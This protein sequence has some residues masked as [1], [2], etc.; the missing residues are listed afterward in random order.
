MKI[1][2]VSGVYYPMTNGVAVFAHN[3]AT[4]LAKRG[5]EVIV[6]CPSFNGKRHI[7]KKEG[8][9]K[10]CLK[11]I[12]LP[13][14]PDQMSEVPAKKKLFGKD[15]PRIIYRRG[16]WISPTPHREISKILRSFRPDI[17]HSQTCDPIGLAV[18]HFAREHRVPFVTTGHTYP[19]T[20]T[21]QLT[22]LK[23][24][25]KPLDAALTS[26]LVGYQRHSD[27]ATM[28]T[29]MAIEDL[30]MKRRREFKVPIEALSN[31]VDLTSFKPTKAKLA[32][33]KK[34]KIPVDRPIVLYVGRVDPEKTISIVLEAFAKLL[35]KIPEAVFVVVGDGTDKAH[36]MELAKYMQIE[37]SVKFLGKILPPELQ[38]VYK[39]GDVFA[40]ASEIETQGIVLIEAAASGLPIIAVDKGAVK[41]VCQNERNGFLCQPG[42][43]I[44]GISESMYKILSDKE[45]RQKMSE[46]SV[47]ISKKHDINN[48]LARFEEIYFEAMKRKAE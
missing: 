34:Y 40:T 32:T 45:L 3:L 41:E 18:S 2:I 10:Y 5:H 7:E 20:I 27:Y 35:E 31:G 48:T 39:V 36:L 37:N 19:D 12:R 30:V 47:E 1:A 25:K 4:G 9:T 33:Y 46:Q 8:V 16:F 14:Y 17:I 22:K 44:D 28:P 13:I 29:E 21:A 42:G 43:D 11:S 23:I 38:E 24:V 6:I 15:L 26:Y